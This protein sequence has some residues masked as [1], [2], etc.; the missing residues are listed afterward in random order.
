MYE[1]NDSVTM[2]M[3]SEHVSCP[4]LMELVLLHVRLK[5][6][7]WKFRHGEHNEKALLD[8]YGWILAQIEH[9]SAI[10]LF[11]V[12]S[13]AVWSPYEPRKTVKAAEPNFFEQFD[14]H[15][16]E[17]KKRPWPMTE[18]GVD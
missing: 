14:E 2:N 4:S 11:Q 18:L 17:C 3:T 6:P 5:Y 15:I 16:M 1:Q 12:G 13:P 10:L 9:D 8:E 7:Y